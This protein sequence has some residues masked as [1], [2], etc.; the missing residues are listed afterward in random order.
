MNPTNFTTPNFDDLR[1]VD[2]TAA[3]LPQVLPARSPAL[4]RTSNHTHLNREIVAEIIAFLAIAIF[5]RAG[6]QNR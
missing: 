1:F 5:T 2:V 6:L 4:V 3:P